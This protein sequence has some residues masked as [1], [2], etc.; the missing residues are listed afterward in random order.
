MPKKIY[1]VCVVGRTSF[2]T[3]IGQMGLALYEL[4][5]RSFDICICPTDIKDSRKFVHLPLA[6]RIR[7]SPPPIKA[8]ATIFA[9]ILWNGVSDFC[10]AVVPSKGLR[11]GCVI[12]DSDQLPDEMVRIANSKFDGILVS[13]PHLKDVA[14]RSG[15]SIP[16][17]VLPIALDLEPLLSRPKRPRIRQ[18]IRFGSIAS[19]HVRKGAD[20]LVAAF[21]QL[22]ANRDDVELVI[23]S[24]LGFSGVFDSLQSWIDRSEITNIKLSHSDLSDADCTELLDSFDVFVNCSRGEGYSIGPRQAL[25]LGK[26]LVLSAVGGHLELSG[27]PGVFLIPAEIS[28]PARYREIDNRVFG[29]QKVSTLADVKQ[30]LDKALDYVVSGKADGSMAARRSRAAD[31]SYT[32]LSTS[33]AE[34]LNADLRGFRDFPVAPKEVE[35][36]PAFKAAVT[37]HIGS[38]ADSFEHVSKTVVP[39]Y[40]GGFFSLFNAFFSHLTWDIADSR[41]HLVLPDWDVARLMR[42][43]EGRP[44]IS[45]CYGKP[46]DGNIWT[47]LFEPL[48]GLTNEMMNDEEFI[49][50]A[51]RIPESRHNQ[52]REPLMTYVHAYKLYGTNWFYRWRR[53]YHRIFQTHI[54]LVPALRTEIETFCNNEFAGHYV[55]AAHV[56]HK[57]HTVEQPKGRIA[58][59]S[60]YIAKI[61]NE[62]TERGLHGR[63]LKIFLATDQEAVIEEFHAAFGKHVVY[64]HDVRRIT[65]SEDR[66]FNRLAKEEQ[67]KD[68]YQLQHRL[69]AAKDRWST[70]FAFEVV[71]DAAVMARANVL[72]HVVSNVS[73][74]VSYMNP[75]IEMIFCQPRN[76]E[77]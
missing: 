70:R 61:R 75:D 53:Q 52:R 58:D 19:F 15:V 11:L 31:F 38:R 32:K 77:S 57:S 6:K 3:G 76:A 74:A 41:C 34:I 68:G 29:T 60:D 39:A 63:P 13:S 44:I 33:Y 67:Q 28:V 46:E 40:D 47:K 54:R 55:I 16:I 42:R 17:A 4:L 48:Y 35:I 30:A 9:D 5:S 14:T 43:Y 21:S 2:H 24:N 69:S 37:A 66:D 22:Y 71:R 65:R 27:T 72:L 23:H 59:S 73:T 56:R 18:K 1:D 51:S 25:A 36:P 64:F 20:L 8:R 10:H 50:R 49:Y 7:V 62:L 45:F 12:L 26:P